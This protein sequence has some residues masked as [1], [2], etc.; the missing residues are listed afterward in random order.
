MDTI[1]LKNI[2]IQRISEI[3]DNTFLNAI[4]TIIDS[5]TDQRILKLTP[6]QHDE[7][8]LSKKEVEQGKFV[9]NA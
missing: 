6:E 8:M 5:R 9:D 2:L 3:D 7:I 4:K 1:E